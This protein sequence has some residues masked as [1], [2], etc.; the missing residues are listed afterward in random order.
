M[1]YLVPLL[2]VLILVLI[3]L[4]M[5]WGTYNLKRKKRKDIITKNSQ[6]LPANIV[7]FMIPIVL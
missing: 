2:L 1:V 6:L 7:E 5:P 4:Q 3:L